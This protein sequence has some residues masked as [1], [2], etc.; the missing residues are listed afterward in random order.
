MNSA[1]VYVL[2]TTDSKYYQFKSIQY[3]NNQL[4]ILATLTYSL[5]IVI[6]FTTSPATVQV[7]KM[8]SNF[9]AY[10]GGVFGD[11]SKRGTWTP[12][13]LFTML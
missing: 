2:M 9:R 3:Y 13:G 5:Y 4:H 8:Y 7:V 1:Q 11:P 12:G 10:G 6:D